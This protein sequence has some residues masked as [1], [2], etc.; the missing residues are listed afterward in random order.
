MKEQYCLQGLCRERGT[1]GYFTLSQLLQIDPKK[2]HKGKT[3]KRLKIQSD[4]PV[5]VQ[6]SIL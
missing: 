2:E 4:A 6:I 1:A 3:G 5:H